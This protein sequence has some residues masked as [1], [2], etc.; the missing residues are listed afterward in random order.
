[1]HNRYNSPLMNAPWYGFCVVILAVTSGLGCQARN[2]DGSDAGASCSCAGT[3]ACDAGSARRCTRHADCESRACLPDGTCA[4]AAAVAYVEAAAPDTTPCTKAIPCGRLSTALTTGKLTIKLHGTIDEGVT[5]DRGRVVTLLGDPGATLTRSAGGG[6]VVLATGTGTRLSIYD[7]TIA[8]AGPAGIRIVMPSS[9]APSV[10]LVRATIHNNPGGGVSVAG[11]SLTIAQSTIS[12]NLGGG[13]TILQSSRFDI[14]DSVFFANGSL[15][16]ATGALTIAIGATAGN[17]LEFNTFYDNI[18]QIGV[19]EA[20]QCTAGAFVARNNIIYGNGTLAFPQ[21]IGG[22][23]DHAYSIV[24]PGVLPPGPGNKAADPR[25]SKPGAGDF[26]FGAG[27]PA[28]GASDPS[29]DL[30]G[31]TALDFDGVPR[32]KPVAIGAFQPQ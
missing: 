15:S 1:M 28:I 23:C 18:A 16:S 22:S 30:C 27:S 5:V 26:H 19:G 24:Q 31:A 7:L 3:P 21:Q 9:S 32:A 29:S 6:P 11:G 10:M 20:I 4:D 25:F 13:I 17:R 8:D 12:N 2:S 14:V